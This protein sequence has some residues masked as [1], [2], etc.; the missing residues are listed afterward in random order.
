VAFHGIKANNLYPSIGMKRAN[1]HLRINFGRQP[2]AFD[3]DTMV[4]EDK[5]IALSEISKTNVPANDRRN[6]EDTLIKSLVSQ[7]LAHDGYVETAKI[8]ANE[9]ND[10]DQSLS[11]KRPY[12]LRSEE[13]DIH[14][15]QRQRIR[16]SILDGDIDRALKYTASC[17]PHVLEAEQNRDVYFHLRCRKFIEMMRRYVDQGIMESSPITAT[18]RGGSFG[19][20]GRVGGAQGDDDDDE[21]DDDEDEEDAEDD[22][23]DEESEEDADDESDTQ[24][25]LDD[26]FQRETSNA[27]NRDDDH[28]E[29]S[30]ELPPRNSKL[31]G[32]DL[33]AASIAYGQ[34]LS[35]EF[36]RDPKPHIKKHLND[37]F[38]VMAYNSYEDSPVAHLFDVSGRTRIAEE[39][40]GAIL[41]Q[42]FSAY[43]LRFRFSSTFANL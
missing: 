34:E 26:Q 24:M 29:I 41:S 10:A 20:F 2:F 32:A 11:D 38:S 39:V 1:E 8:F 25:E 9:V 30:Q 42:S 23:G 15:I 3:I 33:L 12:Q 40:N 6:D 28:M 22:E 4:L 37:I 7:Y 17:Y 21:D 14:A 27:H 13:D 16:R 36:S 31:K 35:Q 18:K 5:R 19:S 43:Y